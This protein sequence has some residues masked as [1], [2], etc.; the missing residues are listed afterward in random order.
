MVRYSGRSWGLTFRGKS[1][2]TPKR[3]PHVRSSCCSKPSGPPPGWSSHFTQVAHF[4]VECDPVWQIFHRFLQPVSLHLYLLCSLF[5]CL[6]FGF[7]QNPVNPELA[8]ISSKFSFD[9][10]ESFAP[11]GY[12]FREFSTY[13]LGQP[14]YLSSLA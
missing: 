3:C 10:L 9:Q 6:H 14:A 13:L 1:F 12:Q 7:L 5:A 11:Y 4:V 8:L 2:D